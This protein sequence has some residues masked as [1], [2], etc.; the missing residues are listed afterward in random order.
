MVN[1]KEKPVV[2][3]SSG[4]GAGGVLS[5]VRNLA[6]TVAKYTNKHVI[7]L[8]LGSNPVRPKDAPENFSVETISNSLTQATFKESLIKRFLRWVRKRNPCVLIFND[9]SELHGAWIYLPMET[10][11]I[12]VLHDEGRRYCTPMIQQ[13][14][15]ANHFIVVA[16]YLRELLGRKNPHFYKKTSII[17]NGVCFPAN[18]NLYENN[19]IEDEIRILYFGSIDFLRKG[20]QDLPKVAKKLAQKKIQ[21]RMIIAGGD[22]SVL[23]KKFKQY[24]LTNKVEWKGHLSRNECLKLASRCHIFFLP[25]RVES[26]GLVTVESMGMGCVPIAYDIE[27]GNRDIISSGKNGFLVPLANIECVAQK[28]RF[29]YNNPH[30]LKKMR[31]NAIFTARNTFTLD[32]AA[33]KYANC[34]NDLIESPVVS[35]IRSFYDVDSDKTPLPSQEATMRRFF[36]SQTRK[37]ISHFPRLV[38]PLWRKFS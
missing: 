29:L 30:L 19:P 14:D 16:E 27:S 4:E 8:G 33:R 20:V 15:V 9:V 28:I 38:Q 22:S 17:Q 13:I 3:V 37:L 34:I 26:F 6:P 2:F 35:C 31:T 1:S 24:G 5:L 32:I 25:S 18:L 23:R 21:F 36:K 12:V 7:H 11:L 10:R